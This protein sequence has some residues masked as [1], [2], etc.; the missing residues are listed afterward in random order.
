MRRSCCG[1]AQ[2]KVS[3]L[4]FSRKLRN[5]GMTIRYSFAL[6][7]GVCLFFADAAVAGDEDNAIIVATKKY[8]AANGY[9]PDVKV[10]VEKVDGDYARVATTPKDERIDPAIAF[11]K[12][13]HGMW[14]AL[15]IGTGF[16]PDDLAKMHIPESLRP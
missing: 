1:F 2:C 4:K 13:E 6:F 12:R 11:L 14:K 10:T 5:E 7:A 9:P 15:A 3:S 8:L 16:D